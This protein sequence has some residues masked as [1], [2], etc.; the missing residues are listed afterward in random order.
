MRPRSYA[1]H[2]GQALMCC[3]PERILILALLAVSTVWGMDPYEPNNLPSQAYPL[4][5]T[6]SQR[7]AARISPNDAGASVPDIDWFRWDGIAGNAYLVTIESA[8]AAGHG[9]VATVHDTTL[10]TITSMTSPGNRHRIRLGAIAG[11]SGP[12]Y[13]SVRTIQ[14][15]FFPEYTVQVGPLTLLSDLNEPNSNWEQATLIQAGTLPPVGTTG[16]L[17]REPGMNTADEDW[18]RFLAEKDRTVE[19]E[20]LPQEGQPTVELFRLGAQPV[21]VPD[22]SWVVSRDQTSQIVV[23][24]ILNTPV[25]GWYLLRLGGLSIAEVSYYSLLVAQSQ[26]DLLLA[27]SGGLPIAPPLV[28]TGEGRLLGVG[29][30]TPANTV[31]SLDARTGD[32]ETVLAPFAQPVRDLDLLPNGELLVITGGTVQVWHTSPAAL[33]AVLNTQVLLQPTAVAVRNGSIYI[34][35]EYNGAIWH[36]ERARIG[37]EQ[38][39]TQVLAPGRAAIG[40]FLHLEVDAT[41]TVYALVRIAVFGYYAL[42]R[43]GPDGEPVSIGDAV[44]LASTRRFALDGAGGIYLWYKPDCC[45]ERLVRLDGQTGLIRSVYT[46]E[47]QVLVQADPMFVPD[48]DQLYLYFQRYFTTS[49]LMVHPT[50]VRGGFLPFRTEP[51]IDRDGIPDTLEVF[52]IEPFRTNRYLRDSDGDGLTDGEEDINANGKLD[53]GETSARHRDTDG[54]TVDDGVEAFYFKTDPLDP[55]VPPIPFRADTDRDR[56]PDVL[57]LVPS[58]A[59]A[60]SD[61][62]ED[63]YEAVMLDRDASIEPFR[64]PYLGDISGD[65]KATNLDALIVHAVF[66]GV[67]SP[68]EFNASMGDTD[69]DGDLSNLDA[70]IIA[71]LFVYKVEYV[72][73]RLPVRN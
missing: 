6:E 3:R 45:T 58:V 71:S 9:L 12:M 34:A 42:Y 25:T 28:V 60:D 2:Q 27:P 55:N 41:G 50:E 65:G 36:V 30:G 22:V 59:D 39:Y 69:L 20:L 57:D 15:Y 73:V 56:L 18:F 70:L 10:Q 14:P 24:G 16:V 66:V 49:A 53:A 44:D 64:H 40:R 52:P 5:A 63:G 31:R 47:D 1:V 62:V 43:I 61:N 35:D 11:T 19:I 32:T 67:N 4:S 51:D 37:Q 68:A 72:P 46:L 23:R 13:V 29:T 17:A 26:Y 38:A 33:R 7:V 8:S 21:A 54:D 48:Q